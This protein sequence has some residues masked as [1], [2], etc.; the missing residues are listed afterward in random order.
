MRRKLHIRIALNVAPL[1]G[2]WI[3]ISTLMEQSCRSLKGR[4][5]RG[6]VD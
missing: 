1:A 3:E 6:G 4:P 2:A 5:P